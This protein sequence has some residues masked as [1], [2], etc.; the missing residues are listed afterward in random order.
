MTEQ[1]TET[2]K[3]KAGKLVRKSFRNL[4]LLFALLSLPVAMFFGGLMGSVG[5]FFAVWGIGLAVTSIVLFVA[6]VSTT[7]AGMT[8]LKESIDKL[9]VTVEEANGTAPSTSHNVIDG[10][11]VPASS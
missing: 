8:N 10:E 3:R 7:S 4:A 5:I 1:T 9:K 11:T 6:I 2:P